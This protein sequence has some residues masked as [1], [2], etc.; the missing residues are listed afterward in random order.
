MNDPLSVSLEISIMVLNF[1]N[2]HCKTGT[3]N[4]LSIDA[5]NALVQDLQNS[6]SA[7]SHRVYWKVD[8]RHHTASGNPLEGNGGLANLRISHKVHFSRLVTSKK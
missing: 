4:P 8:Y 5:F 1:I 7:N 2:M 3:D 6:Y